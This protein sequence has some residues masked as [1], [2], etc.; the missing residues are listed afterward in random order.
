MP[1][2]SVIIP[3]FNGSKY[4]NRTLNSVLNQTFKDFEV[5]CIN[6]K[7]KDN[8]LEIIG[9]F[10]SKDK[11]IK[12]IN[13]E[14]NIGA[15]LSRNKGIDI[16]EGEYIYFLDA[17][18]YID[19]KYLECM[20]K[21]IESENCDIILN[22]SIQTENDNKISEYRHP[23]MPDINPD[24]EYLDNITVTHDAPC[25]IWARMYRKSFLNRYNLR[26]L[27][28]TATDDVVF[29]GIVNMYRDKTFVFYGEKYHYTVNNTSVTGVAKSVDDR[30]LK[31][32]KAY[33]L[34]YD[35][36]KEHDKFDDRLKLF[37][38]FPFFKVI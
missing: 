33:S 22:T 1:K 2:I 23:S 27:D 30:D 34:I 16:A 10:A 24:G 28:I 12:I 17:D 21:K 11:R 36:L 6:D 9:Q 14:N 37:R 32:I 26:F 25:F 20:Y 5:I 19:E 3:V 35:Y 29:N 38:V 13:N 31:H 15:A 8:S 18:D 7:S 4:I